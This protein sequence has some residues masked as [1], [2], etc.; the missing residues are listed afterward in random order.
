[1]RSISK[2]LMGASAVPLVLSVLKAGDSYG[3]EIVQR[4]KELTNGSIAWQEASIYPV[5]KKLEISEKVKSY[6]DLE[7]GDRP[8]KYYTILEDGLKQLEQ[9]K[10]EWQMMNKVFETLWGKDK[11]DK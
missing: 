4:V 8:R 3:Y 11:K 2:E 9:N 5:V 7:T 10:Q 1:M 6:W